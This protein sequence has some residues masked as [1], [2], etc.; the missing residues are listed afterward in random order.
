MAMKRPKG[1]GKLD[2][3]LILSKGEVSKNLSAKFEIKPSKTSH[4]V[5]LQVLLDDLLVHLCT[6]HSSGD[7][8]PRV[9]YLLRQ[10]QLSKRC[11]GEAIL[12]IFQIIGGL[13]RDK[14]NG[15]GG[16]KGAT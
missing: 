3:N 8:H 11:R 13:L 1:F 10:L 14:F 16:V 7:G 12:L 2:L 4:V 9:H 5:Q 15:R 6:D